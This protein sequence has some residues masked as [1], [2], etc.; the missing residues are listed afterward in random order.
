MVH[1]SQIQYIQLNLDFQ[2]WSIMARFRI[3][4]LS[5]IS[6]IGPTRSDTG[7]M[8][9]LDF[10]NWSKMARL[11]IYGIKLDFRYWPTYSAN[12]WPKPRL[13][14]NGYGIYI[15]PRF[16]LSFSYISPIWYLLEIQF[17]AIKVPIVSCLLG[18]RLL[19]LC[20]MCF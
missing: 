3:Y 5:W 10:R 2:H 8:T 15:G 16:G 12:I 17:W 13:G 9:K 6:S 7:Y 11:R 4:D 20:K 19:Y 18:A 14:A 1:N